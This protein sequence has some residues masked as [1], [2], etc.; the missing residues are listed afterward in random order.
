MLAGVFQK[1]K[2]GEL[3][4]RDLGRV[5]GSLFPDSSLSS[6][7][8]SWPFSIVWFT[9]YNVAVAGILVFQLKRRPPDYIPRK[10]KKHADGK[11]ARG[12]DRADGGGPT[13]PPEKLPYLVELSPGEKHQRCLVS[14][15]TVC[16]FP[17]ILLKYFSWPTTF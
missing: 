14:A 15:L 2:L 11:P 10:A 12:K 9:A 16:T 8:V 7:Q 17:C 3:S 1:R 13:L 5:T 6:C 4:R